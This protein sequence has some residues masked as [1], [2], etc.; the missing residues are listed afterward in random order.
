MDCS[1]A[2]TALIKSITLSSVS[3][4]PAKS[5]RIEISLLFSLGDDDV[6]CKSIVENGEVVAEVGEFEETEDS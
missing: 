6:S 3:K 2:N 4:S 5:N 1:L